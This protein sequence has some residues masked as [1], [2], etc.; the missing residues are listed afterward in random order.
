MI[1]LTGNGVDVARH[2][3]VGLDALDNGG[4]EGLGGE[5][6]VGNLT[7]GGRPDVVAVKSFGN[8]LVLDGPGGVINLDIVKGEVE[9][10][11]GGVLGG[12]EDDFIGI[13]GTHVPRHHRAADGEIT[14]HN[15]LGVDYVVGG[16]ALNHQTIDPLGIQL[17]V[18]I[19]EQLLR[20]VEVALVFRHG[21]GGIQHRAPPQS[22]VLVLLQANLDG[23]HWVVDVVPFASGLVGVAV[24]EE[25]AVNLEIVDVVLD[26]Q[27]AVGDGDVL[28]VGRQIDGFA[29]VEQRAGCQQNQTVCQ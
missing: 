13:L 6:R 2:A 7:A 5:S 29:L 10:V 22:A 12:V 24:G 23:I 14:D 27:D 11:H 3:V 28:V 20:I 17:P 8:L 25:A 26:V 21:G 1:G 4:E 18:G 19:V 15:G 16:V 9:V